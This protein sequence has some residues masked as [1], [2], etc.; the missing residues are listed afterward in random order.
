MSHNRI[1]LSASE[2]NKKK[3]LNW[4]SCSQYF[5]IFPLVKFLLPGRLY[6]RLG[7]R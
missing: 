1:K 7:G 4:I 3:M 2:R 5:L 6:G